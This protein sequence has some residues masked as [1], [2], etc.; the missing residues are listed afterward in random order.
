[1]HIVVVLSYVHTLHQ[2]TL[3]YITLHSAD[4]YI[5]NNLQIKGH[6]QQHTLWLFRFKVSSHIVSYQPNPLP[7]PPLSSLPSQISFQSNSTAVRGA[8]LEGQ[9][10]RQGQS[11]ARAYWARA[12]GPRQK[13]G[14]LKSKPLY[15]HSHNPSKSQFP[16]LNF[17]FFSQGTTSKPPPT[18]PWSQLWP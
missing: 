2:I 6:S 1:M 4:V 3:H 16:Q 7:S 5:R 18:Y 13:S 15:S 8:P 17:L 12:Q 10:P 14:A 11:T 9:G